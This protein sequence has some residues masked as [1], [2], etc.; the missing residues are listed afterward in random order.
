MNITYLNYF[1]GRKLKQSLFFKTLFVVLFATFSFAQN[2]KPDSTKV[3]QLD[4]VLIKA[5]RATAKTPVSFSNLDK[6]EI[7]TRNLGQDIP[8]LMNF[9]PSVV[10]TSDTGNGI[11]YTG[12]RVRG[13][14]ATRVNV[15][16]NGIPYNDSESQGTFWVNMPDFASSVQNIQ[17]QRGVGTSTNGSGAFGAS[18]NMLTDNYAK[19]SSGEISNSFGSFNSRRHTVKFTT[20]LMNKQ[21]E[22]AGRFSNI[23]SDGF[24]DRASSDLKGY[25][26]QGTFVGKS[27]LIKALVFGGTERTYQS[28][29]G[30]EDPDKLANNRTYNPA[31]AYTDAAGNEQFYDNETD[32]YQQDHFQLHWS[33][34]WNDNWNSNVALHYT[35]GAGYFEQFKEDEKF[36]DYNW[37]PYLLNG[38]TVN[39]TDLVR[40]RWLDNHFYGTTFSLNY[41]K[42]E[43]DFILGG[44]I[45]KYD[46]AHYGEVIWTQS[47]LQNQIRDRYY[48]DAATKIDANIFAKL[49]YDLTEN[50]NLYVDLQVR[51]VHY[52]ANAISTG[53][54]NDTFSFFNPKSG[55]SF[56]LNTKSKFY[57]SYARANREPSRDDYENATPAGGKRNPVPEQ[58]DDFELGWRFSNAK[59][60]INVNGYFMNYKNQLVL[61]GQLNN[62]G[63]AV[64]ENVGRSYRIGIE[65]DAII[66]INEQWLLQFN[67]TLSQNKNQDFVFKRDGVVQNLGT[68]NIA[69]SPDV[70]AANQLFYSPIPKLKIALLS[71]FVGQQ[72]MGN[73]D[74]ETSKLSSYFVNDIN[75]SYEWKPKRVFKSVLISGLFNNILNL[76]Y[77]SNGFFYTYDDDFSTPNQITTIEGAGFYPQ[78]GAHFLMGLTLGF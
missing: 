14:D 6:K 47:A 31:G 63:A 39:T 69:Y 71:K 44:G 77:E 66:K 61:S 56:A 1:V 5:V 65:A 40:R 53:N 34:K 19:E 16:V 76:Q 30:L 50:L 43:T 32:N 70:I 18:L 45:N 12:I 36:S 72:F 24:I 21:F 9:M 67:C 23:A 7:K 54:V 62:V 74:A 28:W 38:T 33:E 3:N 15:T 78:A 68:T 35:K 4:D 37:T 55:L 57:L 11:G 25:F 13:S 64:R 75:I 17:L 42:N 2:K 49:N 48:N 51:N 58:L 59:T 8:I 60:Q 22:I 26:L 46:G 52:R 41:K 73:I 20:G 29:F 27:T 10:T